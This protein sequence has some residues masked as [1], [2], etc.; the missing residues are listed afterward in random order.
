MNN[1]AGS[2]PV[3][4]MACYRFDADLRVYRCDSATYSH[5]IKTLGF[6][7]SDSGNLFQVERKKVTKE[8]QTWELEI[9]FCGFLPAERVDKQGRPRVWNL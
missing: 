3:P 4:P 5:W 6:P 7:L 1:P 9:E 2:E 8:G